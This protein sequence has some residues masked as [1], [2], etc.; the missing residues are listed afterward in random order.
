[1]P[2]ATRPWSTDM[3]DR[4]QIQRQ[5]GRVAANQTPKDSQL[6]R[7]LGGREPRTQPTGQPRETI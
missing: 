2:W 7:T 6:R 4:F 5:R 1:M 3:I